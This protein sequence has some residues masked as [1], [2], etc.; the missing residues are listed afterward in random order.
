MTFDEF[1]HADRSQAIAITVGEYDRI[2]PLQNGIYSHRH[3]NHIDDFCQ[4]KWSSEI[5]L[6]CNL[7][8]RSLISTP[9][10][11]YNAVT[12]IERIPFKCVQFED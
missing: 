10:M 2:K 6:L 3:I 5:F 8:E 12:F 7:H 4:F 1:I 9:I 11:Y